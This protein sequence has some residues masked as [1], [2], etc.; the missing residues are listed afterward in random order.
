MLKTHK[1]GVKN[2]R[3][4]AYDGAST[5]A[6]AAKGASAIKKEQQSMTNS[7]HCRNHCINLAIAFVCNNDVVSKFMDDLTSVCYFFTNSPKRQQFFEGFIEFYKKEMSI[8]ESDGKHVIGL[9]KTRWVERHKV[10]DN[11]CILYTFIISTFE[12]IC[13]KSLNEDFYQHLEGEINETWSWDKETVSKAQGLFLACCRFDCLTAFSVLFN[14]LERLKP[15][16]TKLQERNQDIS[17]HII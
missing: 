2:C 7:I 10:Y 4:Q 6:S 1:I 5:M 14:G 12:S 17:K 11:Y 9:A 16:V 8:L 3:A 13:N 15:L